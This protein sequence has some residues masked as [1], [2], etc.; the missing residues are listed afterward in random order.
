MNHKK[1][2]IFCSC[3]LLFTSAI[4][5][6]SGCRI[7]KQEPGQDGTADVLYRA[8]C[9]DSYGNYS[10]DL[11]AALTFYTNGTYSVGH[12]SGL[13]PG[14]PTNTYTYHYGT[15][16]VTDGKLSMYN[17][18]GALVGNANADT[19]IE[20]QS[21]WGEWGVSNYENTDGSITEY[22]SLYAFAETN[23]GFLFYMLD[24]NYFYW[25]ASVHIQSVYEND[26][27]A[28]EFIEAYNAEFGTSLTSLSYNWGNAAPT[29]WYE[30][31][32]SNT[33]FGSGSGGPP[34]MA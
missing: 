17:S 4:I 26:F 3:A 6:L 25:G 21:T 31:D 11:D 19:D 5:L 32:S 10:V 1:L 15:W 18:E 20:D 22:P 14:T 34:M 13:M 33:A 28:S 2:F 27:S 30:W 29:E 9:E 7:R 16:D 12:A 24:A 23:D 8:Y